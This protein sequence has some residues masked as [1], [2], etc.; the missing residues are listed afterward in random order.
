VSAGEAP[1]VT[2][3]EVPRRR[4]GDVARPAIVDPVDVPPQTLSEAELV[5]EWDNV[6]GGVLLQDHGKVWLLATA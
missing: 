6:R 3:G 5:Q 4:D 1:A 2:P